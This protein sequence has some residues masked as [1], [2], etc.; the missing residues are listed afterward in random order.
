MVLLWQVKSLVNLS[1]EAILDGVV[2]KC[3]D[4]SAE[5]RI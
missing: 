5:G 2:N 1:I 3:P 4:P